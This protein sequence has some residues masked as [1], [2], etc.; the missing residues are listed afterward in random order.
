MIERECLGEGCDTANIKINLI[1][2]EILIV[3]RSVRGKREIKL[4]R[5]K[6]KLK[7]ETK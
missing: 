7:R 5:K 1:V 3:I 4:S 6:T 2:T